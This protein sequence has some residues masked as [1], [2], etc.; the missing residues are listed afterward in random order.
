MTTR[1][2]AA[3]LVLSTF[4]L[5]NQALAD[6]HRIV[7]LRT[8]TDAAAEYEVG[9]CARPSPDASMG[10]VPGHAFVSFS[11]KPA[12]G[13]RT[14]VAVGHTTKAPVPAALLSY[15]KVFGPVPGYLGE[16]LYTSLK[17]QCLIAQVN[18]EDY[19]KALALAKN[20]L[21]ALGLDASD[22]PV[23]LAYSLGAQ[24]CMTFMIHVMQSIGGSTLKIPSRKP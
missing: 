12:G 6:P 23:R 16:E 11:M 18:R 17:E 24:D 15:V 8:R 10:G 19:N 2:A 21:A 20:P 13:E 22:A 9:F 5:A 7:D 4:V 3:L 1:I 14:Y